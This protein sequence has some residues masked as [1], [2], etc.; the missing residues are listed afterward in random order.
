MWIA[1]LTLIL[2]LW[3]VLTGLSMWK[4]IP[5]ET[6]WKRVLWGAAIVCL[7]GLGAVLWMLYGDVEA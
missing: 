5:N 7:P 6:G 1:G 4:M 3:V 2:L